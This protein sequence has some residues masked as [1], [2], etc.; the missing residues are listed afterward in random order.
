MLKIKKLIFL[1]II[2]LTVN[3]NLVFSKTNQLDYEIILKV[4]SPYLT[5][6]NVVK[7]IDPGRNT[8]PILI[9][10][11]GRVVL[12]IRVIIESLGGEIYWYQ[13][14]RKVSIVLDGNKINLW[15]NNSVA[16]VNG[17]NK[18]IDETN[19]NVKPIIING[20][21]MLPIRFVAEN[22]GCI[23]DWLQ[24][25]KKVVI[26]YSKKFIFDY[27]NEISL[28][29]KEEEKGEIKLKLRNPL[30]EEIKLNLTL[31]SINKPKNWV[32]EFCINDICFFEKGE[33]SLKNNEE[34]EVE[35]YIYTKGKG[36]GEF[37]FCVSYEDHK[38][39]INIK[40]NGG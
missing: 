23:V 21:T 11:W 29:L 27:K 33:I 20:R 18:F 6:N 9:K 15:I 39:C 32:S 22:L 14:E 40:I 7:E 37:I 26:N 5:I 10:E 3:Y 12:P 17:L 24:N 16:N 25:E 8:T 2:F 19:P 34:Q 4:D 36:V 28:S 1:I 13:D 31:Y 30:N 35:I 38:E